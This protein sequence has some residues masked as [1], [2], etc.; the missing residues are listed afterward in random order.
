MRKLTTLQDRLAVKKIQ[1]QKLVAKQYGLGELINL[2]PA[3]YE[4]LGLLTQTLLGEWNE[5]DREGAPSSLED[6]PFNKLAREY[7]EIQKQIEASSS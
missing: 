6:G 4:R 2:S 3:A 1:I 5:A 7:F